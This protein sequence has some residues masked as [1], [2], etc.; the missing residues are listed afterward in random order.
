VRGIGDRPRACRAHQK[1]SRASVLLTRRAFLA[2]AVA[3]TAA[4]LGRRAFGA[5]LSVTPR[6]DPAAAGRVIIVGAG[7]AGLT[8]ALDLRDAGWDVVVLEARDRVGG[9][10]HTLRDPF[11]AGLHAEAGGESI[12]DNH[13]AIQALI[14]RFGLSTEPRPADKLIN[15]VVYYRGQR[16]PML[17]FLTR[18]SG[19]VLLDYLRFGDALAELAE[20]IDPVYPER[21]PRAH[22]LDHRSLD[23]FI[24]EQHLVPGA[25]FLVR[26][27]NRAEY[28]NEPRNLSLL[29]V[30]QQTAVV[31]DVPDTASETKRIAGGNDLLPRAMAAALG[32]RVRL[33]A[34]V[35]RVE[36]DTAG[37]RV[38]AGGSPIDAAFMILAVPM[39][40][41][42]RVVFVPELPASVAAVI[43]GL[44]LGRAAKVM[45]EYS[46]RFWEAEGVPGFTVTDLPFH[47]A[48]AATDSYASTPGILTGF[49]TGRPAGQ[50]AGVRDARRIAAFQRQLDRVYPEGIAQK[51]HRSATVAWANE[52]YT[53]GGY[54][55]FRPGQLTR[56]WPVLR[57]G[58]P[59]I[60]FAGEHT[61]ALAGFMESAVRSGHRVAAQLGPSPLALAA[62]TTALSYGA[63]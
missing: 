40:P 43:R 46:S 1:Q 6:A 24:R 12:D 9:R 56:F 60:K 11:S 22:E 30:A 15:A 45:R 62:K 17:E 36:H 34:P 61:E 32:D 8:A 18:G 52:P 47:V 29:F 19:D 35:T 63:G 39:P 33:G 53:G 4:A 50:L 16:L 26:L 58:L 14:A 48:W 21:A 10:V 37:V 42:R 55:A 51:T 20:G 25:D 49:V 27:Q 31:A 38:Y 2:T 41:L 5:T 3:S 59:R 54:A 44:R 13:G 28:D 23:A 57:D 7:L